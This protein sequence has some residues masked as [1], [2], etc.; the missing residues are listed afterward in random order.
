MAL[1]S[2]AMGGCCAGC[3]QDTTSPATPLVVD[4]EPGDVLYVPPY[5][6]HSVETLSPSISLS[7][8][9]DFANVRTLMTHL[10]RAQPHE[11]D[12]LVRRRGR[13]FALRTYIA[14]L[15][16]GIHG[17]DP[18]AA[19]AWVERHLSSRYRGLEHLFPSAFANITATEYVPRLPMRC[20]NAPRV[21]KC[22][23][24]IGEGA[25]IPASQ[26]CANPAHPDTIPIDE[27]L[28][29]ELQFQAD[30]ANNV[31]LNLPSPVRPCS[32]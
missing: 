7:S 11:F 29:Q 18:A 4:V 30:T 24:V 25:M 5:T 26:I 22:A 12:S 1:F 17:P 32:H 13:L 9:S 21:G 14:T 28:A 2:H 3:I 10:Y 8:W 27:T 20:R 16:H 23:V 6:W 15:L 31:L 19:Q